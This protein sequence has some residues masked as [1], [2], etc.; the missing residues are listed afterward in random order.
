MTRY[1]YAVPLTLDEVFGYLEEEQAV[2]K[3]GGVDLLDLMK[4]NLLAP[5]RLVNV[6]HLKELNYIKKDA[7]GNLHIGPNVTLSDLAEERTYPVLAQAADSAATPQIRNIATLGGNICQRPRCWYFRSKEFNCSRKGGDTC[8]AL[9][10]ENQYHAIFGNGH[11][12]AIVHPSA[13]AVALLALDAELKLKNKSGERTVRLA[14]FFVLPEQDIKRENN[15]KEGELI[16]AVTIPAKMN[17]Y[18]NFYIKQ[19]EKQSFDW[20]IADVA[21]ALKVEDKTCQDARVVLGSAAPI[22]WR[23]PA[24]EKILKGKVITKDVARQAAE[25]ALNGAEP[26]SGNQYKIQVFKAVT[27]RTICRAAGLDPMM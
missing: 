11:G 18:R 20:P 23:V 15:L 26:L 1:E 10:G 9:D 7:E 27:Y 22:P 3:A 4:E 24:A 21:V 25:A 6:R 8:F 5:K 12:C 17:D 19:Q 13:T 2:I 14:D 16:S